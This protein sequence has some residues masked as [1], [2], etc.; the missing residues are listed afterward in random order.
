MPIQHRILRQLMYSSMHFR[1]D[2][3]HNAESGTCRWIF[4]VDQMSGKDD[5]IH[6][7]AHKKLREDA[8]DKFVSWLQSGKGIFHICGK[9]GSGKSTLMKYIRNNPRTKRELTTWAKEEQLVIAFFYFSNNAGDEL[10]MSLDSLYRSILFECLSQC[11]NLIPEVFPQQWQTL[12]TMNGD[13]RLFSNEFRKSKVAEAFRILV[14]KRLDPQY[15]FCFFIDGLDEYQGDTYEHWKLAEMLSD[16]TSGDGIKIC[17]SSRPHTEYLETFCA[18][19]HMRIILQK[20]NAYD[21]YIFS[22]TLLEKDRHFVKIQNIYLNLASQITDKSEGVFLWAV[23]AVR[24]IMTSLGYDDDPQ[25]LIT[26][27]DLLPEELDQLY[28]RLLASVDK[29]DR[30]QCYKMLYLTLQDPYKPLALSAV[31]YSWINDIDDPAFPPLNPHAYDENECSR[32]EKHVERQ[33]DKTTKGLL[34]VVETEFE[35]SLASPFLKYR[36][37]QFLHRTV[38]EFLTEKPDKDDFKMHF[39]YSPP[40]EVYGKLRIAEIVYKCPSSLSNST[41]QITTTVYESMLS[42]SQSRNDKLWALSSSLVAQFR[43]ACEKML[44]GMTTQGFMSI[45]QLQSS[46]RGSFMHLAICSGQHDYVMHELKR[47]VHFSELDQDV[48]LSLII[49]ALS[50]GRIGLALE[51]LTND[52]PIDRKFSLHHAFK[53]QNGEMNPGRIVPIWFLAIYVGL[54]PL[55]ERRSREYLQQALQFWKILKDRVAISFDTNECGLIFA[56]KDS[57]DENYIYVRNAF[58]ILI[59]HYSSLVDNLEPN[60]DPSSYTKLMQGCSIYSEPFRVNFHDNTMDN[61]WKW[62]IF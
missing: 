61:Q 58:E 28:Q 50:F 6:F 21:I 52:V 29:H 40:G 59:E 3:I 20:L 34:E 31:S 26:K 1:E 4:N 37:V 30:A 13:D 53:P 14:S 10:Q 5:D 48:N 60:R 46:S 38:R 19:G 32:R 43:L 39:P 33:L 12:K 15:R 47:T 24:I 54:L 17:A 45:N 44:V 27:L 36:R 9:A 16:W 35:Y 23:F 62:R 18:P 22:K 57:K 2:S 42:L 7:Q 11:P 41:D 25:S 8:R 56:K 49:S 55:C 51:L